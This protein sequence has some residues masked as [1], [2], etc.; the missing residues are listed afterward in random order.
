MQ[1]LQIHL[2]TEK[3]GIKRGHFKQTA[4]QRTRLGGVVEQRLHYRRSPLIKDATSLF[5]LSAEECD[6]VPV[7]KVLCVKGQPAPLLTPPKQDPG[8]ACT[9]TRM[10]SLSDWFTFNNKFLSE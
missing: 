1:H 4:L 2:N 7:V 5:V 3:A 9:Q 8:R 6:S 10:H